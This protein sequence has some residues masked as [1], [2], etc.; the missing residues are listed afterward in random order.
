[1]TCV[2]RNLINRAFFIRI[3]ST[4]RSFMTGKRVFDSKDK[5]VGIKMQRFESPRTLLTT[6]NNFVQSA[7]V[8]I[9]PVPDKS[10]SD[11]KSYRFVY[12][13]IKY[14]IYF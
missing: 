12:C 4:N 1:M 3:N 6:E 8:E 5:P 2:V 9:L 11:K 14:L 10:D 13:F 7:N